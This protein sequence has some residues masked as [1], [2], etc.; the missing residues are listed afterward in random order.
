MI[1]VDRTQWDADVA[2]SVECILGKDEVVGSIPIISSITP[3]IC[4]GVAQFG[5]A[6]EWGSRGRGFNSRRSDQI[7]LISSFELINFIFFAQKY[8]GVEAEGLNDSPA[9]CQIRGISFPQK[10]QLPPLG[11]NKIN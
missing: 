11:P 9:D 5:S 4:P 1:R 8:K 10:R 6:L 3:Y 7:K 2:Q